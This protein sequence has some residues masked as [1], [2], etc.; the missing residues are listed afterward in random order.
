M[1]TPEKNKTKQY[2]VDVSYEA[3]GYFLIKATTPEEAEAIVEKEFENNGDE[4]IDEHTNRDYF[5][6]GTEKVTN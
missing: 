4:N 2:K 3:T 5:I 6:I 1:E